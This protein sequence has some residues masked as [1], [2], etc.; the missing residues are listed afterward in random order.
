[1]QYKTIIKKID[2]ALVFL[3][4]ILCVVF[5]IQFNLNRPHLKHFTQL[6]VAFWEGR[7]NIANKPEMLLDT[8][9][10]YKERYYSILDPLPGVLMMPF[11][12]AFGPQ[13]SQ[14]YLQIIINLINGFI[15]YKLL[16]KYKL[17]HRLNI[18]LWFILIFFFASNMV[19]IIWFSHTWFL[20]QNIGVMWTLFIV[21]E[22]KSRKRALV[23]FILTILLILTKKNMVFTIGAYIIFETLLDHNKW[24]KKI[25][26]L[27]IFCLAMLL[28]YSTVWNYH[29]LGNPKDKLLHYYDYARITGE[30]LYKIHQHGIWN[31]KFVPVNFINYLLE[32]PVIKRRDIYHTNSSTE[33]PFIYPSLKYGMSIFYFSPIFA[34]LIFLPFVM[35]KKILPIGGAV[36]IWGMV[37][38]TYHATGT[39]Q[40]G[41]RYLAE[42]IPFLFI[43]LLEVLPT[44]FGLRARLLT[45]FSVV[46]NIYFLHNFS[47]IFMNP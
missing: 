24:I 33:E 34:S 37:Y 46:L 21:W 7:T 11:V 18:K 4:L 12:K 40:F 9:L 25:K 19:S 45:I 8:V 38:L 41:S 1:M 17:S 28:G 30:D 47:L 6:A 35:K 44:H 10:G 43:G 20:A 42:L 31:I 13:A 3:T 23:I 2:F 36:L 16:D 22:W 5:T 32:G 26:I 27:I 15:I 39:A 14:G 29:L